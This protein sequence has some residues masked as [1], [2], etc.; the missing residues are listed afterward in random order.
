[1]P[2]DDRICVRVYGPKW[3]GDP[4][5][6][7][8][9]AVY[10]VTGYEAATHLVHALQA[11]RAVIAIEWGISDRPDTWRLWVHRKGVVQNPR[12]RPRRRGGT[13]TVD[14]EGPDGTT[15]TMRPLGRGDVA[16]LLELPAGDPDAKPIGLKT[17]APISLDIEWDTPRRKRPIGFRP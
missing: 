12:H 16:G 3:H 4:S 10:I 9:T 14:V 1:M 17:G 5:K 11:A 6:A 13:A 2:T 8:A 7:R 15:L